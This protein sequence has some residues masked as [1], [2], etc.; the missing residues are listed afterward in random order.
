MQRRQAV[1]CIAYALHVCII[2][3][4]IFTLSTLL[5]GAAWSL[6]RSSSVSGAFCAVTRGK[7]M[8]LLQRGPQLEAHKRDAKQC[9][10]MPSILLSHR[11]HAAESAG[12]L[13]LRNEIVS[14]EL[15]RLQWRTSASVWK[16]Q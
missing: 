1:L 15:E 14:C 2:N 12:H 3:Q 11:P 4:Y 16:T 5:R 10:A 8:H 9:Q 6:N 13:T 7:D